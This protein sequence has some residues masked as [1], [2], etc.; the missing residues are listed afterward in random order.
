MQIVRNKIALDKRYITTPLDSETLTKLMTQNNAGVMH[1]I[2]LIKNDLIKRQSFLEVDGSERYIVNANI[3]INYAYAGD[4]KRQASVIGF[5]RELIKL[6]SDYVVNFTIQNKSDMK[7]IFKFKH[8]TTNDKEV[9]ELMDRLEQKTKELCK[10]N[11][12]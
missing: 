4:A 6:K 10:V 9:I 5:M 11:T 2:Y 12:Y 7:E 1:R 8:V 3:S